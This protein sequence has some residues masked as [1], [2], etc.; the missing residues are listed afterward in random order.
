MGLCLLWLRVTGTGVAARP[1]L[2]CAGHASSRKQLICLLLPSHCLSGFS[3]LS[4][5][6]VRA[7]LSWKGSP[8]LA[9]KRIWAGTGCMASNIY[10]AVAGYVEP[11]PQACFPAREKEHRSPGKG[12]FA[13]FRPARPSPSTPVVHKCEEL[14]MTW[15]FPASKL[16]LSVMIWSQH[17]A[18]GLWR[19][20]PPTLHSYPSYETCR[21]C[22]RCTSEYAVTVSST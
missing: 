9:G 18:R 11:R 13:T 21:S 1:P 7:A 5:S 20:D 22:R 3:P 6:R 2:S 15:I 12:M 19:T 4:L 17:Q 8:G 10:P 14:E 16:L